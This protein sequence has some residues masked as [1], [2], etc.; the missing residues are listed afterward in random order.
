MTDDRYMKRAI[1]LAKMGE[2]WCHPNPLVGAVIVKN[3]KIIAEGYHAKFGDLHAERSAIA[4]LRESAEGA[5]VYVTL[6]PCAHQGKQPPC[7]LAIVEAGIKKAVIGSRDPNPLVSG[8]GI[9]FLRENNIEVVEDFMK[10]DCDELNRVFFH[11]ITTGMPYVNLKYAMTLDGKIAT[12]TGESK[13][14]SSENSRKKVHE[15]RHASMGIMTGIG[16][17]IEDDPL[18]NCRLD[19]GRSPLRIICDSGLKTPLNSRIVKTAESFETIIASA[20]KGLKNGEITR[21]II[22]SIWE[23]GTGSADEN[24]LKKISELLD[25]RVRIF[26]FPSKENKTDLKAL[27]RELGNRGLDSVLIEG[28]GTLNEAALRENLVDEINIFIAHKIFGGNS[29]TPVMGFGVSKVE[30]AYK[31]KLHSLEQIDDD[32]RLTYLKS[33]P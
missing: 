23:S 4:K 9:S 5:T 27:I 6:E 31:F 7:A 17:V 3:N 11:Y 25:R 10:K 24:I 12:K 30:E 29:K 15:L 13:W 16:T 20:V 18:L 33:K 2:G 1:E 14:I 8:K 19:N 22:N 21:E 26:N 32:I 28:G